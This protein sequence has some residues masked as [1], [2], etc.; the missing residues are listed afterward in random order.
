MLHSGKLYSFDNKHEHISVTIA[1]NITTFLKKNRFLFTVFT[2]LNL[3]NV[4]KILKL[5]FVTLNII[6][7]VILCTAFIAKIIFLFLSL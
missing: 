3:I 2:V 7:N 6:S 4:S 5:H 1:I